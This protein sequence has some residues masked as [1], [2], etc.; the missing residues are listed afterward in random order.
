MSVYFDMGGFYNAIVYLY[1]VRIGIG[2]GLL[3]H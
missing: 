1:A 3:S 2:I